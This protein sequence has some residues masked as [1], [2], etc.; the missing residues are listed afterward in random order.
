MAIGRDFVTT[1][2]DDC[3]AEAD[4]RGLSAQ[5]EAESLHLTIHDTR[6]ILLRNQGLY[7]S[8]AMIRRDILIASG[9]SCPM[10]EQ[11]E[12]WTLLLNVSRLTPWHVVPEKLVFSRFHT[13][14]MSAG[15]PHAWLESLVGTAGVWYAGRPLPERL[16]PGELVCALT[17]AG[18]EYRKVVQ[19]FLWGTLRRGDFRTAAK[20][21]A[22]GR[23]LL[24]RR[25]D[26]LYSLIPPQVTW[27]FERYL[28]G[29]H[30]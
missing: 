21:R 22:A 12:D 20:I 15:G 27:R 26:R 6:A 11:G 10:Y 9:G 4:N 13:S 16:A 5:A 29:M 1:T 2:L 17:A 8:S 3:I 23:L 30:K 19:G 7:I 24:P 18:R 14:Q 25:W 28:L